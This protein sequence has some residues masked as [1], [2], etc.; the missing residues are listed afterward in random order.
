MRPMSRD[1]A[2]TLLLLAACALA[3][4]PHAG[5]V[6][7]WTSL[8]CS[9]LLFWRGW[10][11]F[12]GNR[13]P[14]R[15]ILLPVAGFSMAGVYASYQSLLGREAGVAMLVLLLAFKLLE[16]R[17]RR[18]VFV[19]VFLSFFL[20]L[21]GFFHSQSITSA[22]LTVGAV[23]AL[24]CAQLSFQ[25]TDACPPLRRR[26]AFAA[27]IVGL[28]LPLTLVMFILFPRIQGPLWGL[29]GDAHAGKSGLSDSM[30]PGAISELAL[31]GDIA[32]RVRFDGPVPAASRL[33]WRGPVLGRYDGRTWT[34]LPPRARAAISHT[35]KASG[36]PV[37][38]QV[39]LE[40]SGRRSLFALELPRAVPEVAGAYLG[41]DFQL[42]TRD[43][44]NQR[45]RYQAV[46]TPA[47][48]L[49]PDESPAALQHWKGLPPG[50]NPRTLELAARLRRQ[51]ADSRAD[52]QADSRTDSPA[53]E[54]ALVD[55]VL[56]MFR[57][58]PFK[59]TL[60]PPLLG[61]DAVDEFLF[62][63]RTGFCEHYAGAFVVLMRA[64]GIPARVVTGYQGGELNPMDGYVT[65]RQSDA[66]AWAEVWLPGQ[67]WVRVDPTAAVAPDRVERNLA[68]AAAPS[69]LGGLVSFSSNPDS[70]FARLQ[71]WRHGW[72]AVNNTWNQWVLDYS[73][74]RQKNFIESLGFANADWRT[75]TVLMLGCGALATAALGLA[76]L[77]GRR[78]TDPAD[79][80]YQTLCR[81]LAQ[82]GCP[83]APHE[84]PR[85]YGKRLADTAPLA[86]GKLDAATRFL[87]MYEND[88]YG[89]RQETDAAGNRQRSATLAQLKT[90]LKLSR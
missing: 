48:L 88:R 53:V 80:L 65:V 13:L 35:V 68:G 70:W 42:L 64:L 14:P 40:P 9:A 73:P 30:A 16:M 26:L 79:A 87:A 49:Q 15:W 32:F 3:L 46:S 47:Y 90:L 63:T 11:T 12:R 82:R 27:R 81:H 55:A 86:P 23:I 33:Y 28:A 61:R 38:Y 43:P 4:A 77:A 36:A 72:E 6:P 76:L 10:I 25:Y 84:G 8:V 52:S 20:V 2:D 5:H 44:V 78:H 29:P 67:G 45:L 34:P 62:S 74:A 56:H 69:L 7:W 19:V 57:Q 22:L 18:D 31:S 85:A 37:R 54:R 83:R 59:Y 41:S 50:Y 89:R 58:Q 21:T 39:T 17:A 24:L 60:S 51:A 75:L 71:G 66:H 1:K